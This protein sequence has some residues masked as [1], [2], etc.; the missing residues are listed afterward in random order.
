M[1]TRRDL[2]R[3]LTREKRVADWVVIERAQELGVVD[4][5]RS[6]T[7]RE[8]R[9]RIA[10]IIHT[11]TALGR[12]TAQLALDAI[13]GN[14]STIV[15]QGLAL[16]GAAIGTA[17]KSVPPAA[18]A[19]VVVIDPALAKADL[20]EAARQVVKATRP[21]GAS[22]RLRCSVLREHVAVQAH[23]GFHESWIAAELRADA[24]VSVGDRSLELT[25]EARRSADL[26]LHDALASAITDLRELASAGAPPTIAAGEQVDLVLDTDAMLHGEGLGVWSVFAVQAD[27]TLE[28]QGLTRYRPGTPIVPGAAQAPEPLTITSNGDLPFALRSAPVGEDGD[29]V[30]RF[31]LVERGVA[32]GLALTMREAALRGLDPNGGVRNLVIAP[33]VWAGGRTRRTIEIRRLRALSIDRFTGDASLE[34]ALAFD[35]DG[36]ATRAFTGGTVRLDLVAAL[37]HARRRAANQPYQRGA[38]AGPPSVLIEG[39]ELIA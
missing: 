37:A 17:W 38:Y 11:D 13:E 29:A 19:N 2:V 22:A 4:E 23:S 26:Q 27:S 32:T 30:R 12:G 9:S 35:R 21:D 39:I 25:R 34:I 14:S 20:V 1:I 36:D 28:R 10:I 3:A 15:V 18:P 33:G 7:R 6:V 31:A 8:T 24:L 16:A 5:L